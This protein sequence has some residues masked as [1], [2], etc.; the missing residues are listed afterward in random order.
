MVVIMSTTM[1]VGFVAGTRIT[2]ALTNT[3]TTGYEVLRNDPHYRY[4]NG[5]HYYLKDNGDY[6]YSNGKWALVKASSTDSEGH[7]VQK[8]LQH[9]L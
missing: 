8:L 5:T 4:E 7:T 9:H 6:Y 1:D 3:P 2:M